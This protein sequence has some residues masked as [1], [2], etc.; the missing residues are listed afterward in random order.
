[1]DLIFI[2]AYHN[3][4]HSRSLTGIDITVDYSGRQ[5]EVSVF[6]IP[7]LSEDAQGHGIRAEPGR[8]AEA[9]L[10]ATRNPK[11]IIAHPPNQN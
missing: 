8:L 9:I 6:G 4:P 10:T 11:E 2:S 7:P 5:A 1:M 3:E